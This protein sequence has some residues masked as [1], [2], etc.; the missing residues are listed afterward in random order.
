[1]TILLTSSV[2]CQVVDCE[3]DPQF[4]ICTRRAWVKG[5]ADQDGVV[6]GQVDDASDI[7]EYLFNSGPEIC[8]AASD[9]NDDGQVL[10]EDAVWLLNYNFLDGPPAPWPFPSPE[11]GPCWCEL[12]L[13]W[14]LHEDI[15]WPI[16]IWNCANQYYGGIDE[17]GF[18]TKLNIGGSAVLEPP[19]A[20]DCDNDRFVDEFDADLI[21]VI[22]AGL[23][24]PPECIAQCDVNGDEELTQEDV[25]FLFNWL[26]L[27]GPKPAGPGHCY[28]LGFPEL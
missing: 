20:G 22:L 15:I 9:W 25:V 10:M 27:G 8:L 18:A 13:V 12:D 17:N 21:L 3:N 11:M 5:D 26:F 6:F 24:D 28:F 7:L 14:R 4:D 2:F 1:M 16:T 19:L 23:W